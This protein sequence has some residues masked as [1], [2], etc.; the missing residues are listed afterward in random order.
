MI[1]KEENNIAT[2]NINVEQTIKKQALCYLGKNNWGN[3]VAGLFIVLLP[4]II[5]YMLF[6]TISLLAGLA[7]FSDY[8]QQ[9]LGII[10]DSLYLPVLVFASPL[11]TGYLRM[12][13]NI[14][15]GENTSELRDI[16]YFFSGGRY[17]KCLSLNLH[18]IVRMICHLFIIFIVPVFCALCYRFT[19]SPVLFYGSIFLIVLGV[20]EA[21]LY[22]TKYT[23]T[24]S[25][26]FEGESIDCGDIL[27]LGNEFYRDKKKNTQFLLVTFSPLVLLCFFVVPIIFVVPYICVSLMNNGKWI[28]S[29]YIK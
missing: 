4:L 12:C 23:V 28:T 1:V 7:G 13:Y 21:F 18:I 2:D 14:T 19:G 29:L 8:S 3:G 26:Y 24:L 25:V 11:A 9:I 22:F 20:I 27:R 5:L 16:F 17:G 10:L 15:K 6:G